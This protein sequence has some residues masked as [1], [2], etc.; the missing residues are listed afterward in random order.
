MITYAYQVQN[1][2]RLRVPNS[3][4]RKV[5][6]V[7]TSAYYTQVLIVHFSLS[8]RK[9]LHFYG[10]RGERLSVDLPSTDRKHD[11]SSGR[12]QVKGVKKIKRFRPTYGRLK[13]ITTQRAGFGE[14]SLRTAAI[15]VVF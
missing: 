1:L 12:S 3:N 11:G 5:N 6:K 13:R 7:R 9:N 2:E 10:W 4:I 14:L 8:N 15:Q